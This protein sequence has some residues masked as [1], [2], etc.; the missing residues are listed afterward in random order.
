MTLRRVDLAQLSN[1][2]LRIESLEEQRQ[3]LAEAHMIE[4]RKFHE[5]AEELARR[6]VDEVGRIG[7]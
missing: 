3:Q 1:R 5:R 4:S 6:K 2:Q 7:V